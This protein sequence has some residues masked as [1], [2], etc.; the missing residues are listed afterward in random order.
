MNAASDIN[1]KLIYHAFIIDRY[2]RVVVRYESVF[3]WVY[4]VSLKN[5]DGSDLMM[6]LLP[7]DVRISYS[8]PIISMI[9]MNWGSG[10]FSDQ[11]WFTLTGDWITGSQKNNYNK[12]RE[13]IYD[14]KIK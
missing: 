5:P 4:D 10:L 3:K 9:G 7:D 2:K 12:N 13:M 1:G 6:P 11:G 14:F 8:T